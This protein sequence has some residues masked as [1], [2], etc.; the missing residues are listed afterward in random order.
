MRFNPSFD[1]NST[2]VRYRMNLTELPN[3]IESF[4]AWPDGA[5]EQLQKQDDFISSLLA[6]GARAAGGPF[7]SVVSYFLN[8]TELNHML[9]SGYLALT[10]NVTRKSVK[11]GKSQFIDTSV[12]EGVSPNTAPDYVISPEGKPYNKSLYHYKI[13]SSVWIDLFYIF[14]TFSAGYADKKFFASYALGLD[15]V[16]RF[17]LALNVSN[18][19]YTANMLQGKDLSE[20]IRGLIGGLVI[21][22]LTLNVYQYRPCLPSDCQLFFGGQFYKIGSENSY[23]TKFIL[24]GINTEAVGI[25]PKSLVNKNVSQIYVKNMIGMID[26]LRLNRVGQADIT[27]SLL[28][29]YLSGA[30]SLYNNPFEIAD[31]QKGRFDMYEAGAP[32]ALR[33]ISCPIGAGPGDK[34]VNI[35]ALKPF[36][37]Y[38]IPYPAVVQ[39]VTVP[40]AIVNC[41]YIDVEP[42]GR[43]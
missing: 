10:S 17:S 2:S 4:R 34:G 21:P 33:Q 39:G 26:Y 27:P 15:L 42:I 14:Q 13:Y 19:G 22:S 18:V 7:G 30:D 8:N 31:I 43:E 20:I 25:I 24:E 23:N 29:T 9:V 16:N 6:L 1:F 40:N 12:F 37:S 32:V 28:F 35:L 38:A 36:T 3:Y 5:Q 11:Q 41:I